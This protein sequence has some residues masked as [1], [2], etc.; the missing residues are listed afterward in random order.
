MAKYNIEFYSES[1]FLL[2]ELVEE[3]KGFVEAEQ[4]LESL[5]KNNT[6]IKITSKDKHGNVMVE[7][8][9]VN[10]IAKLKFTEQK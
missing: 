9:A 7:A 2:G 6:T 10:H 5:L 1:G 8:L 4:K 3:F